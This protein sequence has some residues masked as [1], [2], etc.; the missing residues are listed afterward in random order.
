MAI[1]LSTLKAMRERDEKIAV[2]TCYDASFARV[3]DTAE[4]DVLLVGD[5]LG[6]VIQGHG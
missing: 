6:M 1:T 5:S 4:I 3:L 2:L